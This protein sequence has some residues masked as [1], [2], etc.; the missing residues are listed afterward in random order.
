MTDLNVAGSRPDHQPVTLR[1]EF[2][3]KLVSNTLFNLLGRFWDQSDVENIPLG[4]RS[5]ALATPAAGVV[6]AQVAARLAAALATEG[7]S[8]APLTEPKPH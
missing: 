1:G 2:S 7:T 6:A 8:L 4:D 5:K 3:Q